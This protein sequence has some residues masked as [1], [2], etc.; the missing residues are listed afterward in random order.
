MIHNTQ[1]NKLGG[2]GS[3]KPAADDDGKLVTDGGVNVPDHKDVQS[4]IDKFD[5][6]GERTDSIAVDYKELKFIELRGDDSK[7]PAQKWGGYN[8]DFDEAPHVHVFSDI[9]DHTSDSWGVVDVS[10]PHSSAVLLIFDIDA[11]KLP[12][13][14]NLNRIEL[15]SDTLVTRSQNGGLHVYFKLVGYERGELSEGDFEIADELPIDIRGSAVSAHVVAPQ[16]FPGCAGSYKIVENESISPVLDPTAACERVVLDGAPAIEFDTQA[17]VDIDFDYP[18]DPPEDMPECYHAGLSLRK[19]APDEPSLNTHKVN[20]F[21]ALCGLAAGYDAEDVAV[22]MCGEYAP[23]DGDTDLSD[24]EETEYQVQHIEGMLESGQYSPPALSSLRAIGI[25]DSDESCGPECPVEMHDHRSSDERDALQVVNGFIAEFGPVDD[26]PEKPAPP[27][28]DEEL[29]EEEK[30]AL[31]EWPSDKK[32]TGVRDAIPR[33]A[34][35]DYDDIRDEIATRRKGIP[36]GTLDRHRALTRKVWDAETNI[37]NYAGDL[38]IVDTDNWATATILLNFE[39]EVTALLSVDDEGRMAIIEARPSEPTESEFELHIA[40]RVFNDSRRFKDEVLAHRFSTTI[41]VDMHESDVMDILR[42]Y[43]ASQDVPRRTGQKSMGLTQSG[44]EF[45]TPTGVIGADGWVEEPETVFV[46][47]DAAA[48]R[49]FNAAP[50][51]HDS[52][53]IVDEDVAEMLELFTRTRDPERFIPVLGWWYTAPHRE[54]VVDASGS[55][56]LLFATGESGVGKS[57]ALKVLNRLF[58]LEEAPF[59]ASDTK[60]AHIKTF[61]SSN[62]VPVWLD[63]YKTSEMADWQQSNLHELLRKVA[64]GG[65]EQRGRADQS[66]VE[67]QLKA[68]VCVSGETSIRGSAEQR[69]AISTT[70]TNAPTVSGTPEYQRFKE[71]AGDAVTDENGNVTFPDTKHE[72]EQHAVKYYEYVSAMTDSEFNEKWFS[73]R[74]YVS[75]RLA[76]WNG[77]DLDDL[78]VQ[79]LQTI[80]FGFRTMREFAE[81]MGA[82]L[83][84]IPSENDLDDALRYVADIEGEGRETHIDQFTQL[85]QRATVAE[86]LEEGTHWK[87]VREGKADEEL[88]VNVGR[89]FDAVSKYVRDHDLSEDLLG[90]AKDYRSRFAEAVD[91][92]TY[93]TVTGQNTPP[94]SRCVGIDTDHAEDVIEAFDREVFTGDASSEECEVVNSDNKADRGPIPLGDLDGDEG[95]V[96]VT[97]DVVEWSVNPVEV[98]EAGGPAESGSLTDSTGRVDVV[99]FDMGADG[100]SHIVDE[101]TVRIK[102]AKVDDYNGPQ[103]ILDEGTTI[104]PIQPGVGHTSGMEPEDGQKVIESDA[105]PSDTAQTSKD[106]VRA[107]DDGDRCMDLQ[108]DQVVLQHAESTESDAELAEIVSQQVGCGDLEKVEHR[109]SKLRERGDIPTDHKVSEQPLADHVAVVMNQSEEDRIAVQRAA[110]W[111]NR[112]E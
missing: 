65:V 91:Q 38:V 75:R 84:K 110:A 39:I 58:G 98:C 9:V 66:T 82:D 8:Q 2:T 19:A 23:Q 76:E 59:S 97:A 27:G 101:E 43:I 3:R 78:E 13:D 70:F 18:S 44:D 83:S 40:P 81:E 26:R 45:V 10:H 32:K 92:E 69:R 68:P 62:G 35:D 14:F 16:D 74:E 72:L 61:A 93:V 36:S 111:I 4:T 56:N 96:T 87:I 21:T 73:A 102:N 6:G 99:Q 88:R 85:L 109:I 34:S 100:M 55:M 77:D 42:H 24:K 54:R 1:P 50:E 57:A 108:I 60:F 22:H 107:D 11:Y 49:K 52:D 5:E 106:G 86:Y 53:E 103:I 80:T 7:L 105:A 37:V 31:A 20:V 95:Y 25:L 17:N 94:V 33:L 51:D 104:T 90:S 47:Q 63:E 46:E 15:P 64:T 112:G 71:L 67:Y 79:G 12:E 29:T 30:Q 28:D 48:E 89:A 41:E